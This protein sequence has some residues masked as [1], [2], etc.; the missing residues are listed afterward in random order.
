MTCCASIASSL[1]E[2]GPRRPGV[3]EVALA[4]RDLGNGLRQIT[5]SVPDMR[6]G[7]CMALLES[8]LGKHPEVH[9]ARANLTAKRVTIHWQAE[10]GSPPDF[11]ALIGTIGYT[12]VLP[13]EGR[14]Q[15]DGEISGLL[16]AL[17]V[18]GF[19]SMNIM[20]LSVS[21]WAG[22][23][24]ATRQTLHLMSA[25]LALP[26]VIY[27][28]AT[29]YRSAWR[30]LVHGR[31]NMDVPVS[32]GVLLSFGLS[33]YDTFAEG[34]Q[35]YFE[36]STSL[37]FILLVGRT[38][39]HLMRRRARS[40]AASLADMMPKGANVIRADGRIEYVPL[41][42]IISGTRTLIAAGDRIPADGTI[43]SGLSELDRSLLT[44]ESRWETVGPGGQ[45]CAG[46]LNVGHPLTVEA[47]AAP[48]D[49]TV[50]ELHRMLEAVE[51]GRSEYRILADRAARLYA[52]VIHGLSVLTFL[53]W[54]AVTQDI[55][56]ALTI[57]ISVLIIACPCAL[58]LAVPMVQ[59]VAA[60]RLFTQGIV[61]R[62]GSA[63]ERLA[64]IDTVVLDK[65]GTLT[66]YEPRLLTGNWTGPLEFSLAASLSQFSS[67]PMSRAIA[68]YASRR[69][70]EA[71][72]LDDVRELP[73]N[74][75]EASFRG[76][77][78]RLGR[79]AWAAS[80]DADDRTAAA[81]TVVLTRQGEILASFVFGE[82]VRAGSA[83]AVQFL[84]SRG[85]AV[86]M[87]TGDVPEA[88]LA[89][90]REVGIDSVKAAALPKDKAE[91][92]DALRS[93]GR[94]VMMIGDGINDAV[95]LKAAHVSMAPTSG[96]DIGRSAADFILLNGDM[97]GMKVALTTAGRAA[98]LIR[99]NFALAA[100]YNACSIPLA[101]LGYANPLIAA[102][103]MST[104]SILVVANAMRLEIDGTPPEREMR[105]INKLAGV[106]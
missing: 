31:A 58:G 87:L 82:K 45:V 41:S 24:P 36:A 25:A 20:V 92:I 75:L 14:D 81:S 37:I 63:L 62:D 16:R 104:S 86:E 34:R 30:A 47:T 46:D 13:A 50:A 101:L 90:A 69:E 88:A 2:P 106:G 29:F 33:V 71:L 3:D 52:P 77:V 83:M 22:A 8:T 17:A 93:L 51:D 99:Q 96:S 76:E 32:I 23:D 74:G 61:A 27:S 39:D 65:T 55:H 100:V 59:V 95:A 49:S 18:A 67:H 5:L 35:A 19:C 94:K 79:A 1:H 85:I 60:R 21:V 4:S 72:A 26:A 9:M 64:E 40:A 78:Y 43:L 48:G 28:G 102:I 38:L 44:G 66:Q 7:A 105:R 73:G 54:F 91:A 15:P 84:K 53:S 57:S 56:L 98:V 10:N 42:D 6:C 97:D 80:G 103:A 68:D 89:V 11:A 12:A 70:W